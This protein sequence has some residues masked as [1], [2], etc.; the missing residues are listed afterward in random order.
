MTS[1][2]VDKV[3]VTSGTQGTSMAALTNGQYIVEVKGKAANT[4]VTAEDEFRISVKAPDGTILHGDWI[5]AKNISNISK[6]TA[7]AKVEQVTTVDLGTLEEGEYNLAIVN[8]SDRQILTYRQDKRVYTVTVGA[9]PVTADVVADL[10]DQINKDEAS[11][12]IA[13]ASGDDLVLTAK[14][15]SDVF[16]KAGIAGR[17]VTFKT[18]FYKVKV[19]GFNTLQGTVTVSTA[20]VF[21]K[22]QGYQVRALEDGQTGYQGYFNRLLFP[23]DQYPFGSNVSST[24]NIYVIEDIDSHS[25]NSTVLNLT[26]S[27]RTNII[28]AASATALDLVFAGLLA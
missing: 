16:D 12:V 8:T 14:S 7:V 28:A 21:G 24:Y 20:A 5:K 10:V 19:F 23:V 4:P 18:S 13:S 27:P 11:S 9:T 26:D 17:Q 25:T 15:Q 22:G 3:L 2:R 6:E 1:N